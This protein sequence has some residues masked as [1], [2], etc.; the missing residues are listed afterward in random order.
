MNEVST[1]STERIDMRRVVVANK[2]TYET[3]LPVEIGTKVR[4]PGRG[5]GTFDGEV[6]ALESTYDG[7]CKQILGIVKTYRGQLSFNDDGHWMSVFDGDALV[8]NTDV[9]ATRA[10]AVLLAKRKLKE[11]DP[12]GELKYE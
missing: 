1:S 7:E 10:D 4:L 9:C 3:E 11:L 12:C 8:I 5:G 2:Y 6:T